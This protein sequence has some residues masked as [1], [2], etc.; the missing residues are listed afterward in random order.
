MG[1]ELEGRIVRSKD[2]GDEI[3]AAWAS[4][5]GRD[6]A[7]PLELAILL[8]GVAQRFERF[9][10]QTL[11]EHDIDAAEY[12]VLSLLAIGG[13]AGRTPRE[14]Q[15]TLQQTSSGITRC[16]DRLE[17]K[18]FV[19]RRANLDDRRS[20]RVVLTK[21]GAKLARRLM[22][23]RLRA[24]DALFAPLGDDRCAALRDQLHAMVAALDLA[25]GDGSEPPY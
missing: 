11:G 14:M 9:D 6:D 15:D 4:A 7:A 5:L 20:V 3:T 19:E 25:L 1:D 13:R 21:Q 24:L 17:R 12:M 10:R 23:A 18:G 16:L 22:A 2:A 8:H